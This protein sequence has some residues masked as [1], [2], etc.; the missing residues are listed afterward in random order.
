MSNYSMTLTDPKENGVLLKV[1]LLEVKKAALVLRALNHKLRQQI[2]KLIDE[3]G[4]MTVTELYVKLRLEQSVAS[5]HL[6]ILR[7]AG[8]VKTERDGKFIYYSVNINRIHELNR[9]VGEL[10]N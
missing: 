1:D 10:L 3:S 9:F 4:K 5:Q 6:A 2:L 8:F 7:K